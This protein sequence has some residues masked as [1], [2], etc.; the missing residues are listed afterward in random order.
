MNLPVVKYFL[1]PRIL[2]SVENFK[3]I[4]SFHTF[5]KGFHFSW[6]VKCFVV[7]NNSAFRCISSILN[8]SQSTR[9]FPILIPTSFLWLRVIHALFFF[10]NSMFVFMILRLLNLSNCHK[11]FLIWFKKVLFLK[12][13]YSCT[14]TLYSRFCN[15]IVLKQ[16]RFRQIYS[17]K[18]ELKIFF[19]SFIQMKNNFT[20]S[21]ANWRN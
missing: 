18:I 7:L 14:F 17:D 12:D 13:F 2:C 1:Y 16:L 9:V 8:P 10:W 11:I 15:A 6:H 5:W 21:F 3:L 4:S 20:F 19:F